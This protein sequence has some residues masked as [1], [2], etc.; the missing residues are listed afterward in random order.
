MS[1]AD[2]KEA[3]SEPQGI[4]GA[5]TAYVNSN[6]TLMTNRRGAVG[7]GLFVHVSRKLPVHHAHVSFNGTIINRI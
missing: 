6:Q 2:L 7:K 5:E 1:C 3:T 4:N